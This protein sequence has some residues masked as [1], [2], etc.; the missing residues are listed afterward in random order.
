M[1]TTTW[2]RPNLFPISYECSDFFDS[3]RL[4]FRVVQ[5]SGAYEYDSMSH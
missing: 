4:V 1:S 5:E 3:I 2:S